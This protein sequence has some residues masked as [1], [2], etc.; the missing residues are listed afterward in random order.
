MEDKLKFYYRVVLS[1]IARD[2][3][4]EEL[5]QLLFLCRGE[6]P[7]RVTS[8]WELLV[9]LE[10]SA[11]ISWMDVSFLKRC[12]N[13]M[14]RENLVVIL[15][16]FENKRG[17][18]IILHAFV[19]EK[20]NVKPITHSSATEAASHLVRL[21]ENFSGGEDLREVIRNTGEKAEDLWRQLLSEI[22]FSN[23]TWGKFSMLV[24]IAGEII[25]SSAST[26]LRR[27]HAGED[28]MN[29]CLALGGDLSSFML[30]LGCWVS[31][32]RFYGVNSK[33]HYLPV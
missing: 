8:V 27:D 30:K 2:L 24:A 23:L 13:V 31:E 17:L 15:T 20:Q 32:K 3:D 18:S 28:V 9:S 26:H 33:I 1:R 11:K 7:R 25:S 10:D 6:V 12:L 29:K 14:G 4:E 21:M 5:K 16:E 22:P 19:E